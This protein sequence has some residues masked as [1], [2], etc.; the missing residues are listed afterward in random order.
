MQ[1]VALGRQMGCFVN[2]V[3]IQ[4]KKVSTVWI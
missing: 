1:G 2:A 3:K 4:L